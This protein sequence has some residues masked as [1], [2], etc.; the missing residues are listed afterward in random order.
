MKRPSMGCVYL[1]GRDSDIWEKPDLRDLI[2][3]KPQQEEGLFFSWLEARF[4]H[5]YHQMIGKHFRV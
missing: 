4:L 2:T 1:L 3:L 5:T